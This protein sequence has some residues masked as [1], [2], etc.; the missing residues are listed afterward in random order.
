MKR[1]KLSQKGLGNQLVFKA[2]FIAL[3]ALFISIQPKNTGAQSLDAFQSNAAFAEKIY[4][5]PDT[6]V[7]T[8]GNIVWYKAIVVN[9]CDHV[10]S[11]LSKVLH[12]ELI[13]PEETIHEEKLIQ[14]ADGIGY[15]H[16]YL[17]KTLKE[18][19]YLIRAYTEWDKNFESNFFFEDYIQVYENQLNGN[20]EEPIRNVTLVKG[21]NK[22]R[23]EATFS[24]FLI[25]SLHRKSLD[26][27]VTIDGISDTFDVRTR[28]GKSYVLDIEVGENAQFATL[29]ME[30][31]HNK[32]FSKT[33]VLDDDL[34]DLQFFPESGEMVHGL[35]SRVGFKALDAT[36]Q[37]KMISGEIVDEKDSVITEFKSNTL[38]M[39]AF[40][41]LWVDSAKTY[42][43]RLASTSDKNKMLKFELP[44]VAEKGNQLVVEKRG[45]N[46]LLAAQSNYIDNDIVYVNVSFRGMTLYD[47]QITLQDGA[48][49]ILIPVEKL[50]E[51]IIAFTM[52]DNTK[53]PVAER[54]YFNEKP[55]Q[56]INL[57]VNTEK[58]T[59][60]KREETILDI[61]A[62]TAGG[63]PVNANLSVL[64]INKEQLGQFQE[65]R[66]NIL[67]YLLLE[68]ELK[69]N[70]ENPGYYFSEN[71]IRQ[72]DLDA[73]MLTQGWRKY[74]YA[75]QYKEIIH[76]PERNLSIKGEVGGVVKEENKKEAN[77]VL[78]TFGKDGQSVYET[79]S[80]STGHFKLN[81]F[82]EFGGEIQAVIQSTKLSGKKVDYSVNLNRD[83]SPPINF[84]HAR[85]V[86][87]LDGQIDLLVEKSIERK[88]IDDAFP[89]DSGNILL[90]EVEVKGFKLTPERKITIER[91][92]DPTAIITGKELQEQEEDW[93]W[94]IGS[95]LEYSYPSIFGYPTY[96]YSDTR[97]LTA[98]IA[99]TDA[100]IL[101]IDGKVVDYRDL[102]LGLDYNLPISEIVGI[103]VIK[104]AKNFAI[105]YLEAYHTFPGA[106]I[107]SGS[108]LSIYTRGGKG[109]YTKRSR[110]VTT[111]LIQ[112]FTEPQEFYAPKYANSNP[113]EWKR[114]DLRALIHWAPVV[115]TN[116]NGNAS[117]SFYNA[118]NGGEM[119]VI[120]EAI[121]EYGEIG[122]K[123][124]VY[125]VDG[126]EI[127]YFSQK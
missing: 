69:G 61:Q 94:G 68:S 23:L 92:G 3:V 91:F 24:P 18:G 74:N 124:A 9:A 16:F 112:V 77:L 71:E 39:G 54:L 123:E 50:P 78:M 70:I 103:D 26:V 86:Q 22:N 1:I 38:G 59:Y 45:D 57:A 62:T 60:A 108:I 47:M 49:S 5:Q 58:D 36:G 82:D 52:K 83:N 2:M 110:G 7:Y 33:V 80:D 97:G 115:E 72:N 32:R 55:D 99:G 84:N 116:S 56:R 118:D 67:S 12:V 125:L 48:S 122:Y 96:P 41:L 100:T 20:Q 14:L 113:D 95:V 11:K 126:T 51:G 102:D 37:G 21:K 65:M 104:D 79:N 121:S 93:S 87:K 66:Q 8:L 40:D 19:T 101:M 111:T 46:I 44:D 25:D 31:E 75:K 90:D 107:L 27:V 17:N 117:V 10:P 105:A 119:M 13:T 85:T 109:I 6:K 114:P 29:Y 89:L 63:E 76:Y 42:Y 43:A 35:K 34:L 73:L 30:T 88:K 53:Q 28:R 64:V 120:V 81:L 15:G 106:E 4:L 98:T 127:N